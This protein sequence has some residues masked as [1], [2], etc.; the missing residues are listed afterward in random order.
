MHHKICPGCI[1]YEQN[2]NKRELKM[3]ENAKRRPS[4]QL[5]RL[6]RVAYHGHQSITGRIVPT[7]ATGAPPAPFI[8]ICNQSL[9]TYLLLLVLPAPGCF[10]LSIRVDTHPP[11][12]HAHNTPPASPFN[13]LFTLL[14]F[15]TRC[16]SCRRHHRLCYTGRVTYGYGVTIL[17]LRTDSGML[18][19]TPMNYIKL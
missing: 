4:L 11:P 6:P 19:K 15:T 7:S 9:H 14:L 17:V 3:R 18:D 10:L 2:V 16:A 8:E 5:A 1:M 13:S 12:P